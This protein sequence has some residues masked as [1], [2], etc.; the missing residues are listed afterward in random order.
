MGI[1]FE[2]IP[3]DLDESLLPSEAPDTYVERLALA[4]AAAVRQVGAIALGA[5]TTVV[6]DGQILGKPVDVDD[7]VRM[8]SLLS[9]Q[10]HEVYT[11][12]GL[13]DGSSVV[14]RSEVTF[15]SLASPD[16]A[17]YVNT[18]EPMDRAGAYAVQ[19]IGGAFVESINGSYSNVVGLPLTETVALLRRAGVDVMGPAHEE[20]ST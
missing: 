20:T 12:V 16:I 17:W 4:K 10:T 5:D 9:G 14:V 6:I 18:G 2:V 11:G 1:K 7:A 8:L 15:A 19:G 3:A 13:S